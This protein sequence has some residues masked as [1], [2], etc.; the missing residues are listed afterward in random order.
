MIPMMRMAVVIASTCL[1]AACSSAG[2]SETAATADI[3]KISQVKSSFGQDFKVRD[4]P[5]TGIDPKVLSPHKLPE[6]MK[7]DPSDCAKFVVG[8]DVPPGLQGILDD[9]RQRPIRSEGKIDGR[10]WAGDVGLPGPD[11]GKGGNYLVLPPEIAGLVIAIVGLSLP[12]VF[13]TLAG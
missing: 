6:G 5:K 8:Q 7:F 13:L 9:F 2:T 4:I 11:K 1:L 10:E 12:Q 3:T